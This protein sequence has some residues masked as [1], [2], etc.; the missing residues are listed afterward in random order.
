MIATCKV[1]SE[2]L[3]RLPRNREFTKE[4]EDPSTSPT[5]TGVIVKTLSK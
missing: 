3:Q 2:R 1:Q 4:Q 5:A